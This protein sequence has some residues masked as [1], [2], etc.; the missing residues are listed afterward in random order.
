MTVRRVWSDPTT[1]VEGEISP[2]GRHLSFVDWA[3]GDLA[4]RDL[5]TGENRRLTNKG[6]WEDSLEFALASC[7]S[8]DG[9]QIA[10]DWLVSRSFERAADRGIEDTR[11]RT[12]YKTADETLLLALDWSPDGREILVLLVPASGGSRPGRT[13]WPRC[14]WPRETSRSSRPGRTATHTTPR[15]GGPGSLRTDASSCTPVHPATVRRPTCSSSPRMDARRRGSWITPP[16]TW[17]QV[18]ARTGAGSCSSA[19]APGPSIFGCF[20]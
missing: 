4:V 12:V 19:T 17:P 2:D 10:Y 1:D 18:G 11:S 13:S 6:S 15:V 3:T 20:R 7:W 5:A 8:P 16:T 9:K 14:R